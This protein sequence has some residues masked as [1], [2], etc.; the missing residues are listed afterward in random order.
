M[1]HTLLAS[2][3][4]VALA[5]TASA[6]TTISNT[7]NGPVRTSTVNQGAAD[8]LLINST[9]VVNGTAAGGVIIDSNHKLTNQGTIQIG[10]VNDV[11]G[12]EVDA[13]VTGGITH[14]GKIIVDEA[15]T[16]T[17]ADNDGDL[18]GPF[19]T[20]GDRTGLRTNG[21]FTGNVLIGSTGVIT[22]EGNNW[23]GIL[24]GGA[25]TGNFTHDGK[26]SVLG[27]D[28]VGVQLSGVSGNARLAGEI[29]AQGQNNIAVRSTANV[30]GATTLQS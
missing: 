18:D 7:V 8:D 20:G 23:A 2:T 16:P 28:S 13:G 17:D 9:G 26:T 4:F 10:S 14:T 30:T 21:A 27:N 5:G 24:V 29:N 3:C 1:R 11:V 15:Y 19:A 6:E 22:V 12:V 25:L